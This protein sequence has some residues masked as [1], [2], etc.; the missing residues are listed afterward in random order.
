VLELLA[1]AHVK[2]D[3]DDHRDVLIL[4]FLSNIQS[5]LQEL[6]SARP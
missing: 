5:P 2:D 3:P 1:T 4:S 6:S